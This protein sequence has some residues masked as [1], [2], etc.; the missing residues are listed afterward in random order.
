[1]RTPAPAHIAVGD[2]EQH[3]TERAPPTLL[4]LAVAGRLIFGRPA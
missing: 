4:S 2:F 3:P 1:V